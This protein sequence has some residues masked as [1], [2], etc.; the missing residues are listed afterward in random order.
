MYP[1]IFIFTVNVLTQK[2][3]DLSSSS[4]CNN[5]ALY[6][7]NKL[8]ENNVRQS[9]RYIGMY[10]FFFYLYLYNTYIILIV[11]VKPITD[12]SCNLIP[13]VLHLSMH[14]RESVN[15]CAVI[16]CLSLFLCKS[17]LRATLGTIQQKYSFRLCAY[18]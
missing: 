4:F 11:E 17:Y 14:T 12:L 9:V 16:I 6:D 13:H 10:F 3:P 18:H 15:Y 5:S 2:C 7:I 1:S 8:Y